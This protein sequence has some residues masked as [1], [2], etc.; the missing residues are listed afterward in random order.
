MD[1]HRI[2]PVSFPSISLYKLGT[3]VM[4]GVLDWPMEPGIKSPLCF[5]IYLVDL[6]WASHH[7]SVYPASQEWLYIVT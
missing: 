3:V 7:F 1:V 5:E 2:E 4:A 6:A